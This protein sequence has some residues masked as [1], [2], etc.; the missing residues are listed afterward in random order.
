LGEAGR[1][2]ARG[3]EIAITQ[4]AA[5]AFAQDKLL[6]V[7]GQ[8]RHQFAFFRGAPRRI[9]LLHLHFHGAFEAG[10][11]NDGAVGGGG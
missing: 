1:L 10:M 8:I 9:I 6:A 7:P 11:A 3:G 4:S 2:P 5:P